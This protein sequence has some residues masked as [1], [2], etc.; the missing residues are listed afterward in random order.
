[1]TS[2]TAR[3]VLSHTMG[4]YLNRTL[5]REPLQFEGLIAD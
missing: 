4:V 1:L 2:R 3:K 5:G